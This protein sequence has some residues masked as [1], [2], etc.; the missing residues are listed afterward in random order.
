MTKTTQSKQDTKPKEPKYN[1]DEVYKSVVHILINGTKEQ[2]SQDWKQ[3]NEG[4]GDWVW[5]KMK[6]ITDAYS[7]ADA[8]GKEEFTMMGMERHLKSKHAKLLKETF[9]DEETGIE[10]RVYKMK[11]GL[12]YRIPIATEGMDKHA[13]DKALNKKFLGD[14]IEMTST[15][16]T[17]YIPLD[18]EEKVKDYNS[19]G[20]YYLNH[21][22][23]K[24]VKPIVIKH[25]KQ[26]QEQSKADSPQK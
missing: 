2:Q 16:E 7:S 9:T 14:Y 26:K 8:K 4:K 19:G 25:H 3:L 1:F 22:L 23:Y 11:N 18:T 24:G 5:L 15:E 21:P 10:Y 6:I 20:G 17:T 12:L 13:Y